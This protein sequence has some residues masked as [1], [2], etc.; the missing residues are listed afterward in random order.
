MVSMVRTLAFN[1]VKFWSLT[2]CQIDHIS[3][4][5]ENADAILNKL[6]TLVVT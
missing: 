4:K 3:K 6:I 1:E 2:I 5:R